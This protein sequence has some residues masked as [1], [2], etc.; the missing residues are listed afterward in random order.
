[1]ENWEKDSSEKNQAQTNGNHE[2]T[3]S[4]E[5]DVKIKKGTSNSL[6]SK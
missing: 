5:M 2:T 4:M 3:N 1:M 6:K